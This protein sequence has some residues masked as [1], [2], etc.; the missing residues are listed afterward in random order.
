MDG[1]KAVERI[2]VELQARTGCLVDRAREAAREIPKL[3]LRLNVLEK[4]KQFKMTST[5]EKVTPMFSKVT[6]H[7]GE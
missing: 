4:L 7:A 3:V 1:R 6:F 2:V 5:N